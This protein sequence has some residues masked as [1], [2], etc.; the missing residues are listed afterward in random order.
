MRRLIGLSNET[1]AANP[2]STFAA[3]YDD[4]VSGLSQV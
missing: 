2:S 3:S 1:L 4:Y